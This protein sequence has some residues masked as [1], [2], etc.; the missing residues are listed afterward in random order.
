MWYHEKKDVHQLDV[1]QKEETTFQLSSQY[2][3]LPTYQDF[4]KFRQEDIIRM[5]KVPTAP[6]TSTTK[7]FPSHTSSS[8]TRPVFLSQCVDIFDEPNCDSTEVTLL[9][10]MSLILPHLQL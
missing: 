1:N 3:L 7:L 4:N 10:K 6:T 2:L 8:K 9:E 5:T